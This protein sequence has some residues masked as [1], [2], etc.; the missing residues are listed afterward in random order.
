MFIEMKAAVASLATG[1]AGIVATAQIPSDFG[2]IRSVA[3]LGS[4]GLVAFAAILLLVKVAPAFI[5]HLDKARD[6]FLEELKE[7]RLQRQR[8]AE[9]L[10]GS[11]DKINE[12][13][14]GIHHTIQGKP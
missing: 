6:R 4:F 1:T 7:E 5:N 11:L 3:E 8:H 13:L 9:Q 14:R 2:W 10:D 12:S